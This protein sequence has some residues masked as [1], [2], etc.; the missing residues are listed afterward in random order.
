MWRPPAAQGVL[1]LN[2][3]PASNPYRYCLKLRF[4]SPFVS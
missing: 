1:I 2:L 3:G 4:L